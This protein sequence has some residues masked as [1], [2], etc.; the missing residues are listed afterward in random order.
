VGVDPR[1]W[2]EGRYGKSSRDFSLLFIFG[3]KK[4]IWSVYHLPKSALY[5][6]LLFNLLLFFVCIRQRLITHNL[7]A[8]HAASCSYPTNFPLSF[9]NVTRVELVESPSI[10]AEFLKGFWPK[11]DWN[12]LRSAARE[13]GDESLPES[14]PA[15][16]AGDEQVLQA[17]W[18]VLMDVSCVNLCILGCEHPPGVDNLSLS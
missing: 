16:D 18:R 13:L 17:V 15:L 7:L 5:L 8:C 10:S 6:G 1:W 4:L 11:V 9:Q 14:Q 12:A 3:G 2:K